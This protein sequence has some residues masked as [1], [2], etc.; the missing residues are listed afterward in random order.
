M[1]R[2]HPKRVY[3]DS[4]YANADGSIDI[5]GGIDCRPDSLCWLTEFSTVASWH[6]ID[7]SNDLFFIIEKTPGD[8]ITNRTVVLSPG[9]YDLQSLGD[10]LE[11]AL[12]GLGKT[13]P[14][15]Y[16]VTL[17]TGTL[18]GGGSGGNLR[19]YAISLS[20]GEFKIPSEEAIRTAYD[21]EGLTHSTNYLFKFSDQSF[22]TSHTSSMVDLRRAHNLYIW[23]NIGEYSSLA[24]SGGLA[25]I[26][27]KIGVFVPYG[28]PVEF[29]FSESL[30]DGVPCGTHFVSRIRLELRDVHG[31]LVDL[32]GGHYSCTLVFE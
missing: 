11:F 20:S 32:A 5:P 26:I 12:N 19:C 22:S 21:I 28:A 27:Q 30:T 14:G 18:G 25:P 6:T 23:M 10:H 2:R 16:G 3:L 13:V 15:S 17:V 7:A 9:P 1:Q 24:P 8:V 4:R 31:A 29:R